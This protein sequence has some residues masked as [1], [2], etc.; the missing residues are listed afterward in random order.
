LVVADC[1]TGSPA[2]LTFSSPK[3]G[4]NPAPDTLTLTN[5]GGQSGWTAALQTNDGGNW[6]TIS[7]SQGTITLNGSENIQVMVQNASLAYGTYQGSIH[8]SQGTASWS[9]TVVNIVQKKQDTSPLTSFVF[10]ISLRAIA[11]KN[12]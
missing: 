9:V 7:P 1:I 12:L 4:A 10:A 3:K 11:D 8:F 6:L 5:C 2:T